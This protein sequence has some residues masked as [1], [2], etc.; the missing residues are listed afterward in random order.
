M[1]AS[2]WIWWNT[3]NLEQLW[4]NDLFPSELAH[5]EL[6]SVNMVAEFIENA[7]CSRTVSSVYL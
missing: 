6:M 2:G 1:F 3:V 5:L 7:V 4:L